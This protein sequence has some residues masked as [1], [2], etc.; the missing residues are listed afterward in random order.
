MALT[1]NVHRFPDEVEKPSGVARDYD[2]LRL[3]RK[4]SCRPTAFLNLALGNAQG[5]PI[6]TIFRRLEAYLKLQT[7]TSVQT[8]PG[9]VLH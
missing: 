8:D 7:P 2:K 5:R 9:R 4:K 1:E 3:Q 6:S